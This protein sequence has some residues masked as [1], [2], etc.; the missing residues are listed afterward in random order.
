[1]LCLFTRQSMSVCKC[2]T[3][4]STCCLQAF[5][6]EIYSGNPI[7]LPVLWTIILAVSFCPFVCLSVCLSISLSV[8]PFV[9]LSVCLSVRF[10]NIRFCMCVC[11]SACLSIL[12]ISLFHHDHHHQIFLYLEKNIPSDT[13]AEWI[14]KYKLMTKNN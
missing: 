5:I 14:Y 12:L 2:S 7:S 6:L 8:C 4:T 13:N 3:Y 1:L 9:C 10:L 11:L